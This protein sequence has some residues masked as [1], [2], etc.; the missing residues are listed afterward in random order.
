[1]QNGSKLTFHKG[2]DPTAGLNPHLRERKKPRC[3]CLNCISCTDRVDL[4]AEG[5][6]SS[7]P[8]YLSSPAFTAVF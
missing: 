8:F 1:M 5:K 2:L 3:E 6:S 4:H 7:M